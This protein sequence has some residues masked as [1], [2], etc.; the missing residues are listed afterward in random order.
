MEKI[1]FQSP[2]GTTEEFYVEE[3]TMIAGKS[4]L[5]VSHSPASATQPLRSAGF[6]EATTE[7]SGSILR[8]GQ[9]LQLIPR[10]R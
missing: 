2:D 5:L 8:K 3:Q 10:V 4:Y 6:K 9:S 7:D 1:R